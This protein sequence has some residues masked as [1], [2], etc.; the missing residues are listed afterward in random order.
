MKAVLNVIVLALDIYK[1]VLILS[2][3]F[4]WLYAFNVING[5]NQFVA[6]IGNTLHQV[7]HPVLSKIRRYL[8]SLGTVDI[9]PIIA[10]LGI[11]LIQNIILEYIAPYVF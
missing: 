10:I 11:I 9:S 8:P 1:W 2:A 4:S 5:Q 7:T 3:V 6:T